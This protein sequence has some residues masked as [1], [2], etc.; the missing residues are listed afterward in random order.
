M[1]MTFVIGKLMKI[2]SWQKFFF[3]GYNIIN[4]AV[5]YHTSL[6]LYAGSSSLYCSAEPGVVYSGDAKDEVSPCPSQYQ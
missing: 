2:F 5:N 6:L 4:Y 1:Y 3:F